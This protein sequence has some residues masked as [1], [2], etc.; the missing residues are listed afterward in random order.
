MRRHSQ[1]DA[2]EIEE[3]IGSPESNMAGPKSG[4]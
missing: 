4:N 1:M 2:D 3:D